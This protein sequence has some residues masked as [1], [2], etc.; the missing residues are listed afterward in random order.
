MAEVSVPTAVT[1]DKHA[2]LTDPVWQNAEE[3]PD[4]VQFMRPAD[5]DGTSGEWTHVSCRRFRDEVTSLARGLIASGVQPGTRVALMSRTRYE[6]TLVD[7][8]TWAVGAVTVPIYETASPDQ[9]EW[10][11]SN[12]GASFCVVESVK[13]ARLVDGLRGRLPQLS[14]LWQIDAGDLDQLVHE[15]Q[16]VEPGEVT[17]RR[18]AVRGDDLATIVYTSGTTGRPKGCMLTHHNLRTDVANAIA[19]LPDL[20]NEEASTLLFLPL[21]HA[22][23]RM[24]QIGVVQTRATM[25]HCANMEKLTDALRSFRPTFLLAV[26]RVFEKVHSSAAQRARSEGREPTFERAEQVAVAY[27]E[28][29]EQRDG[30]RLSLRLQ[31]LLFDL[32]VYR[33]VRDALGGR[34]RHAIAGGAPLNPRLAHF[35]RGAGVNI[36]EG[37]GLTE[38]S[39][40]ATANRPGATRIGTVGQPLPGVSVRIDDSGEVLVKGDIVF[41]GYW[42]N[43]EATREALSDGWFR[44]GD[45]GQLDDDGYLR[46][47]GRTKEILVTA[48]GKHVSPAQ[49]EERLREHP[50]VSHAVVIGD[51]RPFVAAL[52]SIDQEVWPKWLVEHGHP[53]NT[54]VEE[55]R[56]DPTLRAE[57]QAAIDEVNKAVSHPEAIKSFR[58]LPDDF[59]SVRDELTPTMKVKRD[60]VT[61]TRADEI[62]AIY[63]D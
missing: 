54:T 61:R 17:A 29:L 49:L 2:N 14:A 30:P 28:A 34:C 9:A 60:V 18:R 23:A 33:K 1:V 19:A 21:A 24:V 3:A 25:G 26:P 15:G 58:I 40:A 12:S 16:H 51:R 35:F 6:W 43:P 32:L 20:F 11:L 55:L 4:V 13:H 22:F 38:T 63:G 46:I 27:S 59:T 31:H 56:D 7:Y 48:G 8:A 42:N 5:G 52:I 62:A 41:Q 57:I 37:Y 45:I 10:I 36:Y 47:T 44:S 50:L 39:P 53:H